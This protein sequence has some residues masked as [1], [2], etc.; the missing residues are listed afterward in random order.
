VLLKYINIYLQQGNDAELSL[1]P[2]M[3][4]AIR[5]LECSFLSGVRYVGTSKGCVSDMSYPRV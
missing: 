5:V 3:P 2:F 4:M 1:K